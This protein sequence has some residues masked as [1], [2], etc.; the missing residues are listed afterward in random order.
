MTQQLLCCS[1]P[2]RCHE[3]CLLSQLIY[4]EIQC[5][6]AS[7]TTVGVKYRARK[8]L[9]DQEYGVELERSTVEYYH[10]KSEWSRINS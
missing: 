10:D 8:V 6:S 1:P 7:V 2:D 4:Q 3:L 5:E 9:G